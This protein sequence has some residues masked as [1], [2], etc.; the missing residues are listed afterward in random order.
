MILFGISSG[1]A[2]F[3]AQFWGKK[4]IAGIRRTLGITLT[5]SVVLAIETALAH[6]ASLMP[7]SPGTAAA[8]WTD[9]ISIR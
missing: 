1:G 6:A 8:L 5:L 3:V 2:I 7:F 4:D 9:T